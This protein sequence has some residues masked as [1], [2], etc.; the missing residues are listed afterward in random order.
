MK[1]KVGLYARNLFR[2]SG[3][4]IRR[5]I[6]EGTFEGQ[7]N[8]EI[9][10]CGIDKQT[11]YYQS[12]VI[13]PVMIWNG[14]VGKE[15]SKYYFEE[16]SDGQLSMGRSY[17]GLC[18]FYIFKNNLYY[19]FGDLGLY[20][21]DEKVLFIK[22]YYYKRSAKFEKLQKDIRLF[23]KMEKLEIAA[24]REPIPGEVRFA[25]WRRDEGKCVKCG[26][27]EKLEFDHVIPVS[28]GGSNTERNLQILCE[29]C[30]RTKSATI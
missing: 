10:L 14:S 11:D 5:N 24:A 18:E 4:T 15:D 12:T 19:I 25:V 6:E 13:Q 20:D 8:N 26:S 9:D 27:R 16:D 2:S 7:K 29:K 17:K 28:K 23:E 21:S 30:N 1:I 3:I 22:E